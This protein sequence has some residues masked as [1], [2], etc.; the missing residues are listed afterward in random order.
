MQMSNP[1]SYEKSDITI[2]V[3]PAKISANA[4]NH[5]IYKFIFPRGAL[6]ASTTLWVCIYIC[7]Y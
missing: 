2:T 7:T 6:T 4:S 1:Y 3:A 5:A